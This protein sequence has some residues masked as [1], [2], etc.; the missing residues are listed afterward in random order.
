[1]DR[2]TA[3]GQTEQAGGREASRESGEAQASLPVRLGWFVLYWIAGVS[4]LGV[5]AYAIRSVIL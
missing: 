3:R 1:M 5:I 4:V 2:D